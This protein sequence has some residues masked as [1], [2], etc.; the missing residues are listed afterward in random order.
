MTEQRGDT[1][2]NYWGKADP[3]CAL[4]QKWH[5]LADHQGVA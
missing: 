4:E 2:F 5:P 1:I 3:A